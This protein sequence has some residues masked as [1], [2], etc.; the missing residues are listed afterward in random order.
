MKSSET[1]RKSKKFELTSDVWS[2][3]GGELTPTLK[4]KR[5]N[6]KKNIKN[7][8]T[9]FIKNLKIES[10]ELNPWLFYSTRI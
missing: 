3:D 5:K 1:G 10:H 7:Y 4:L 6:V 2:I 8:M 9:R